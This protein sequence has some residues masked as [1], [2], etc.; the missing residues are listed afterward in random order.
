MRR[1]PTTRFS[2]GG[3]ACREIVPH[4]LRHMIGRLSWVPAVVPLA[5]R[6]RRRDDGVVKSV[7][8]LDRF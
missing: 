4:R 1:P 8:A 6:E 7:K 5:L 2:E 3:V